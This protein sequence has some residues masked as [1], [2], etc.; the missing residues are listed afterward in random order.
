MLHLQMKS[1]ATG[2]SFRLTHLYF[3]LPLKPSTLKLC[4][5]EPEILLNSSYIYVYI[6][7]N[8]YMAVCGNSNFMC[9]YIYSYLSICLCGYQ[10]IYALILN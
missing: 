3:L 1:Q 6:K 8:S 7:K 5:L 10:Y 9:M 4:V 2:S